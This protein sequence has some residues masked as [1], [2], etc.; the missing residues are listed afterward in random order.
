MRKAITMTI[1]AIVMLM[2]VIVKAVMVTDVIPPTE[3]PSTQ[4]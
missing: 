1:Q 2:R 3:C 4:H